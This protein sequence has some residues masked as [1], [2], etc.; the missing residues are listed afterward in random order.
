MIN[1]LPIRIRLTVLTILVLIVCCVGL[2]GIINLSASH[3]ADRIAVTTTPA[4]KVPINPEKKSIQSEIDAGSLYNSD[5]NQDIDNTQNIVNDFYITSLFYMVG[6]IIIGGILTYYV[7]GKALS[8][9]TK[10]NRQIQRRTIYNL[11]DKLETTP[12]DDEISKITESF[13]IMINRI[14]G[15]FTLQKQFSANA[16]HELRTP[17]TILKAKIDVFNKKKKQSI[18]EYNQLLSILTNQITRL[19]DI[20][21]NLLELTTTETLIEKENI[22]VSDIMD[23]IILELNDF[24]QSKHINVN[25]NYNDLEVYGSLD[26][27]YQAFYNL[28]ENSIK[29]NIDN[30]EISIISQKQDDNNILI[31]I[32]DT[33][34]GIPTEMQNNIFEPFYRVDKSRS[35]KIGGSGLG[36]SIVKN[37]IEKHDGTVMVSNNQEQGS[38][39]SVILPIKKEKL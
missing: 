14:D 25:M 28:I 6:I 15:A 27:L 31:Q 30:G 29:Y 4:F 16:A 26:L 9:L 39:F 5:T 10:L 1:K 7:S 34:I 18:D 36:L 23:D 22:L 12:S 2:T 24:I 3:M 8:P 37:I 17:L 19:S 38:C 33:G 13:N 11:S 20:V 32:L 21:K 35:R